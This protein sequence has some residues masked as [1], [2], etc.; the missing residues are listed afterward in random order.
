MML[1]FAVIA[2]CGH[3]Y[4]G[5]T[6]QVGQLIASW[7]REKVGIEQSPDRRHLPG[8]ASVCTLR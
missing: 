8:Q 2:E 1:S 3:F 7:L 6:A 4:E 5:H